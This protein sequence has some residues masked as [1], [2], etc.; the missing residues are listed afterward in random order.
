MSVSGRM[1]MTEEENVTVKKI[2]HDLLNSLSIIKI[3][4]KSTSSLIDK[5]VENDAKANETFT[6]KQID[7]F[8]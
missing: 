5:I 4:A 1:V 6:K 7:L 3:T 8:F 2:Q